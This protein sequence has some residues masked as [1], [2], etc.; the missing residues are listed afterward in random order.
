MGGVSIRGTAAAT[1]DAT[2]AKTRMRSEVAKARIADEELWVGI[3]PVAQ[4]GKAA[5]ACPTVL[6]G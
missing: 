5:T 4:Y 3:S 2:R 6:W 1:D